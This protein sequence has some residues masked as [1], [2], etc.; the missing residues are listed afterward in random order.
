MH[1]LSTSSLRLNRRFLVAYDAATNHCAFYP[2]S[3]VKAFQKELKGYDTSK[4]TIR[5]P[6]SKPLPS[7]LVRKLVKLRIEERG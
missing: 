3:T 7:A 2:G 6:A 5:F 4:G 1:Q